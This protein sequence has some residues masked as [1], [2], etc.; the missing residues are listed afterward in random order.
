M[1]TNMW[2]G[3]GILFGLLSALWL[4]SPVLGDANCGK[5]NGGSAAGAA[6]GGSKASASAPSSPAKKDP[7]AA[8]FALPHGVTLD[9]KQQ[10]VYNKLK[11]ENEAALR[12]AIQGVQSKNKDE[13][14][15]ALVKAKEIR[16]K[17]RA[18]MKDILAM[19]AVAAQQAAA[20]DYARRAAAV[21]A[22]RQQRDGACPCGR[23]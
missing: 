18:G 21:A 10:Q 14:A 3:C 22:E 8:A 11:R 2:K 19:P 1:R 16:T 23:R 4:A 12:A 15:K 17:V 5:S 20:A 6:A 9:A 7:A 13:S